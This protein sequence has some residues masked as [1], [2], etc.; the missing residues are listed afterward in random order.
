MSN[1]SLVCYTRLSPNYTPMTNKV[2]RK[3]TIHHMAGN[4]SIE[5]CGSIFAPT[6]RQASSNYG[7]GSDGRIGMYV[8]ECNRSWCSSSRSNDE[9]AITIEVANNSKGPN[10]TVSDKAMASLINLCED[11]CRRNNIEAINYTGDTSGNLT[12][13]KWFASTSCPGPYLS[14]K[15]QFIADTVNERL[16]TAIKNEGE[17]KPDV[18]EVL[19]EGLYRVRKK[20]ED[21]SS[22]IGAY[23]SLTNAKNTADRNKDYFVF[24][25]KGNV[26]YPDAERD[27][28][29]PV[30]G[31]Y[32]CTRGK[33]TQLTKNFQSTEFDCKGSG[34]CKETLIDVDLLNFLQNIRDHFNAPVNISNAYRC[35]VHNAN[36]ENTSTNSKHMYGMAADIIVNGVSPVDV[37]KYAESIGV[38]GIGLYDTD[39]EGHFV[40]VDTRPT[41]SFWFGHAQEYRSTFGGG[42]ET[43]PDELLNNGDENDR[44]KQLQESLIE[45]GYDVGPWGADSIFGDKTEEAVKKFQKDFSLT[46]D[47]IV[48]PATEAAIETALEAKREDSEYGLEDFIKEVQQIIGAAVDGIAGPETLSKTITVSAKINN[49]HAIVAPIQRRLAAMGYTEVGEVDGIAGPKFTE[50]VKRLQKEKGKFVDGEITK[51]HI[52]WK[53]ILGML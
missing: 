23:K 28:K 5:T 46:V 32:R 14:S 18:E 9:Q 52:T 39:T 50:A 13:H 16:H 53:L 12:M 43:D 26:V 47:G 6:S 10:W 15:F 7:I 21:A 33:A 8:E 45:L 22:Q 24:D 2:N 31:F 41:K 35:A 48:G 4:C 29:I 1:S 3:I 51:G 42:N 11:I 38:L 27:E 36:S 37:A 20:W 25:D 34:C 44:V 19:T 49:N 30:D 17:V 40:H